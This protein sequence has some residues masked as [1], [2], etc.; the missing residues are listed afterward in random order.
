MVSRDSDGADKFFTDHIIS[1]MTKHFRFQDF[2]PCDDSSLHI[3]PLDR[4]AES[5][6]EL[7]NIMGIWA[8]NCNTQLYLQRQAHQEMSELIKLIKKEYHLEQKIYFAQTKYKAWEE[9][10]ILIPRRLHA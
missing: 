3:K 4:S 5:D 9:A 7:I 10:K 6:Q 1:Y 2:K 8:T